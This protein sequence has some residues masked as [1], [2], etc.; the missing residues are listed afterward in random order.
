MLLLFAFILLLGI[1]S[2][3]FLIPFLCVS[4]YELSIMDDDGIDGNV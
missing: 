4:L 1:V 3:F 2:L